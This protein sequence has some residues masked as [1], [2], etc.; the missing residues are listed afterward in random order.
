M[1]ELELLGTETVTADVHPI[2]IAS[3]KVAER[4]GVV[5]TDCVE[6]GEVRWRGDVASPWRVAS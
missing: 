6:D 3:Q 1:H 4:A 2:N 5:A